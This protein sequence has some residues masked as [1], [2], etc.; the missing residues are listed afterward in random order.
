MGVEF[1]IIARVLLVPGQ[2]TN[3]YDSLAQQTLNAERNLAFVDTRHHDATPVGFEQR[4]VIELN[5]R[6]AR[7]RRFAVGVDAI[8]GDE[9]IVLRELRNDMAYAVRR[10]IVAAEKVRN[11]QRHLDLGRYRKRV[12]VGSE[13]VFCG[14]IELAIMPFEGGIRAPQ[15]TGHRNEENAARDAARIAIGQAALP[16]VHGEQSAE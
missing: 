14:E 12:W 8:D 13:F 1:K 5:A 15:D 6:T 4:R 11:P 3:R 7:E 9:R 16:P 2:E 10:V